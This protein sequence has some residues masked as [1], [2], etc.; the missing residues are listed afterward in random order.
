[1]SLEFQKE[2]EGVNRTHMVS[3][4]PDVFWMVSPGGE[5]T[6]SGYLLLFRF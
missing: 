2:H 4:R 6:E 5:A 1:M 3:C